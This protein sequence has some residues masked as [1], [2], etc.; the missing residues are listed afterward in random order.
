LK[1]A[2]KKNIYASSTATPLFKAIAERMLAID[3]IAA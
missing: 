1:K 3:G 2:R